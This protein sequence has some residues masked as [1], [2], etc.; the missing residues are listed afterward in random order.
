MA[1]T[2]AKLATEQGLSERVLTQAL[3]L[4]AR[5]TF[6]RFEGG[7]WKSSPLMTPEQ[8]AELLGLHKEEVTKLLQ[9]PSRWTQND[10]IKALFA[11]YK[12]HKRWPNRNEWRTKHGLPSMWT[13]TRLAN[14]SHFPWHRWPLNAHLRHRT[15]E[16]WR[17]PWD[18]Y[19][20]L[21]ARD[22]RC[23]ARM[24]FQLRNALARKEAIDRIGFDAL[25]KH[26]DVVDSHPEFGTL[27]SLPGET[28]TERM[29]LIKVVNS[30]PE[31]DGTFTDYYLRVPPD[32]TNVQEA[33]A[34][35]FGL[36]TENVEYR[37]LIET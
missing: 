17:R 12:E 36:N 2:V 21:L 14:P 35:T 32:M 24:A 9:P 15:R 4:L 26:A 13:L 11:F 37:P 19:Q 8:A 3:R 18:H 7:R 34:W 30:T 22:R 25:I 10:V 20:R 23:T 5:R 27:Y 16:P 33:L 1:K 31:P 29:L 28:R 6:G